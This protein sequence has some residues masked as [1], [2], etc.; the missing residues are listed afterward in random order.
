M[1]LNFFINFNLFIEKAHFTSDIK[2]IVL[3]RHQDKCYILWTLV[4][5]KMTS[6][7]R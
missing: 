7:I 6:K 2:L 3:P 1:Q 4:K 5:T